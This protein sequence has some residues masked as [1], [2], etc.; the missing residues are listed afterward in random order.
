MLMAFFS[1]ASER[2]FPGWY[3]SYGGAHLVLPQSWPGHLQPPTPLCQASP[4][5]PLLAPHLLQVEDH[6]LEDPVEA[7]PAPLAT[8]C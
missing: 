5:T 3:S 6:A 4:A 1:S 8:R 2:A 7:L